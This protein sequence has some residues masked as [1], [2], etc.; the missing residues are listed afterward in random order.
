M[1]SCAVGLGWDGSLGFPTYAAPILLHN[2]YKRGLT[3]LADALA[4]N[5]PD[6]VADGAFLVLYWPVAIAL[7]A[8]V[9]DLAWLAITAPRQFLFGDLF[10]SETIEA[11]NRAHLEHVDRCAQ[12][13]FGGPAA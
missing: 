13:S 12:G 11:A 8:M 6:A 10:T 3:F 2:G 5:T 4:N 9:L 1:S 7:I